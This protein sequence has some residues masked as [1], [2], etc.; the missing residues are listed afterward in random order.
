MKRLIWLAAL[1]ATT[2][3]AFA[4]ASVQGWSLTYQKDA[5]SGATSQSAFVTDSDGNSLYYDCGK[6]G[7]SF[8]FNLAPLTPAT[9]KVQ[10]KGSD[11]R[12]VPVSFAVGRNT[13]S[14]DLERLFLTGSDVPWK[15]NNWQG[16]FPTVGAA[17]VF[18]VIDAACK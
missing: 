7:P 2:T 1:I 10:F 17:K 5:F 3:P 9:M 16:T 11:G 18:P 14:A 6:D 15:F 13:K 4:A 12:I 8:R